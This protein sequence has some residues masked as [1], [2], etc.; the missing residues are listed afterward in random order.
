MQFTL[1]NNSTNAVSLDSGQALKGKLPSEHHLP[2]PQNWRDRC[3]AEEWFVHE[4]TETEKENQ[5][6][7][8]ATA[9]LTDAVRNRSEFTHPA[10]SGRSA[11]YWKYL[12]WKLRQEL[13]IEEDKVSVL[14]WGFVISFEFDFFVFWC[15]CG[16][17]CLI[18][19]LA[20][21]FGLYVAPGGPAYGQP[22]VAVAVFM[23]PFGLLATVFGG[24]YAYAKQRK[25]LD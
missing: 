1:Y 15:I 10:G 7:S 11:R 5:R 3:P 13:R 24:A 14:G 9:I 4:L 21:L 6:T 2:P 16:T 25:Y 18:L 17:A 23:A 22:A 19:S 20:L 8:L 12:P